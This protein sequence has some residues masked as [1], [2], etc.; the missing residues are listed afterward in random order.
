MKHLISALKK[1][2]ASDFKSGDKVF[3]NPTVGGGSGTF[4]EYSSSGK[5]VIVKVK[6]QKQS[7]HLSDISKTAFKK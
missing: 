7:F 6:G 4:E 1:I 5:Y 2:Q 3:I